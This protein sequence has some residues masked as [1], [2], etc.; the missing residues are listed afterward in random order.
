M[1]WGRYR[2]QGNYGPRSWAL[3]DGSIK[4]W[5][6]SN[7]DVLTDYR[8]HNRNYGLTA[9]LLPK[10]RIGFDFAYNYDHYLQN[11]FI[12]FND[13]ETSLPVV[14]GAGSC[15]TGGY[16]DPGNTLLTEGFYA[17]ST[18][19]YGMGLLTIKPVK[20]LTTQTGYSIP[21]VGGVTLVWD[22]SRKFGG[23]I[24]LPLRHPPRQSH[25]RLREPR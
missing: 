20:R 11:A 12:C 2:V 3:I 22:A 10:G 5:E 23:R 9:N 17:S 7:G 6:G 24:G 25:S 13:S 18:P 21:G 16:Q 1:N 19:Y 14:A 8:G 15:I 4:L